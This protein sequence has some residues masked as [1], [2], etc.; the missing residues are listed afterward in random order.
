MERQVTYTEKE[1]A[2]V[3]HCN[4]QTVARY[5]KQGI[6][7]GVKIGTSYIYHDDE[8]TEL[9]EKNRGKAIRKS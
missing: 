9:F 2:E 1:L 7:Q 6:L 3:L 4:V 8:I 5:R